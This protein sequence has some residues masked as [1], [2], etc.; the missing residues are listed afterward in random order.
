[1]AAV[2]C[3]SLRRRAMVWRSRVIFTR[4]SRAASSAGDGARTCTAA[5]GCATGVGAAAA[6]SIAASMSPLV[7][8]PSLPE[9]ATPAGSTPA[10]GG[11]AAH[12][13][14]DRRRSARAASA[15]RRPAPIGAAVERLL[16][17]FGRSAPACRLGGG[18]PAPSLIWPS[19]APTRD[20]LAVLGRDL[21]E[22]AGGGR[23]HLDR[24]LVGFE[25]DQ[26][27]VDR[28]GVAGL[29]EPLADGRLGDGFAEGGN[30]DFSHDRSSF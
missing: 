23:R 9:P 26:R 3:A 6:R 25:L 17:G 22:H 18:A 21:G 10:L 11:D 12:R 24:H 7:T 14:R 19:S 27:L 8:R 15:A 28:D 29:L 1:M 4:S 16:A 30:A 20:G 5:A 13:R 2:F